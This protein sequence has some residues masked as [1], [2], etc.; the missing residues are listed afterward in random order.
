MTSKHHHTVITG[1]ELC[2]T[3]SAQS[4][5]PGTLARNGPGNG[6]WNCLSVLA[7][8]QGTSLRTIQGTRTFLGTF[9]R[10]VFGRFNR[11]I[12]QTWHSCKEGSV[13]RSKEGSLEQSVSPGKFFGTF[14]RTI[15]IKC[16][17]RST[18]FWPCNSPT[19]CPRMPSIYA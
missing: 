1:R 11:T 16:L 13:E 10:T 17:A 4:V 6:P 5:I 3:S 18:C 12:F 19:K 14:L 7:Q 9:N 15:L 8:L 2:S